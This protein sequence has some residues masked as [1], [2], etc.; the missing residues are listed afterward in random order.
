MG[1]FSRSGRSAIKP[2][3]FIP[4]YTYSL[5]LNKRLTDMQDNP[6]YFIDTNKKSRDHFVRIRAGRDKKGPVVAN[7]GTND[8]KR[9]FRFRVGQGLE[10]HLVE[11]KSE[12]K[13]FKWTWA[14]PN[15]VG[16]SKNMIWVYTKDLD[17]DPHGKHS[18]SRRA[19][20]LFDMDTNRAIA[21]FVNERVELT[22]Q[23][24]FTIN[25]EDCQRY[26]P[27]FETAVLTSALAIIQQV[28]L[29]GSG[30]GEIV[31][32]SAVGTVTEQ[33]IMAAFAG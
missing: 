9:E 20:K 1:L 12:K 14:L 4:N 10:E 7:I 23:G 2:K 21:I 17:L 25:G 27:A 33:A 31:V 16:P 22:K 8:T 30:L 11:N 32:E 28:G 6:I 24:V 5:H 13:D 3:Q 15:G 18:I 29:T 26:G 19:L